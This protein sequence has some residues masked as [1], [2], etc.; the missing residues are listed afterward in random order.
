MGLPC[1]RTRYRSQKQERLAV[2]VPALPLGH[3]P[4]RCRPVGID[5]NVF[6]WRRTA[7]VVTATVVWSVAS[8]D[9]ALLGDER[10]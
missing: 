2:V 10:T 1:G 9:L 6:K 5:A 4:G 3:S 7:S 8:E